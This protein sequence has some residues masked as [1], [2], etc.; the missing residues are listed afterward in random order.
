[1]TQDV[2]MK[3]RTDPSNSV[4]STGP[5]TLHRK[6]RLKII[7]IHFM[8]IWYLIIWDLHLKMISTVPDVI[9]FFSTKLKVLFFSL[10]SNRG[11]GF[12]V[13]L[14]P[15]YLGCRV[16]GDSI[17]HR[18]GFIHQR[19]AENCASYSPHDGIEEEAEGASALCL[20]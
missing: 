15:R 8:N 19:G 18:D 13:H 10:T 17:T 4:S 16:E 7:C 2:E 3:D 12:F 6:Y 5:S 9:F 1:M 14:F 20:S 11:L